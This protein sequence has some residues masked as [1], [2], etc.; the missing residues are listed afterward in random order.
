M[1]HVTPEEHSLFSPL[2][3]LFLCLFYILIMLP[4]RLNKIY[5]KSVAG[6]TWV[7]MTPEGLVYDRAEL[8]KE[9]AWEEVAG[10]A[11]IRIIVFYTTKAAA[12]SCL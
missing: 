8:K 9:I 4:I 10:V 11:F 2:L 6:H 1:T 3:I 5:R 7:E 12:S